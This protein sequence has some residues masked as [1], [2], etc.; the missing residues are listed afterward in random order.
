MTELSSYGAEFSIAELPPASNRWYKGCKDPGCP[1]SRTV[2]S[3][4][5][6]A[7]EAKAN[8]KHRNKHQIPSI[9]ACGGDTKPQAPNSK[10]ISN[11]KHQ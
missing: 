2:R 6:E 5:E 1:D 3:L 9:A 7:D 11:P 10:Q 8:A 4:R